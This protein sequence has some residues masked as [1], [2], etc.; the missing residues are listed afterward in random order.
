MQPYLRQLADM[1]D[2][3]DAA[4]VIDDDLRQHVH[5]AVIAR[6]VSSQICD[7]RFS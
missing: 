3:A 5:G 2:G 7:V 6:D 1:R 4:L